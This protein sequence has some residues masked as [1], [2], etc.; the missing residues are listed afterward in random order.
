MSTFWGELHSLDF[1]SF[2][3]RICFE[4]R[5]SNFEFN[6]NGNC[7]QCYID[8]IKA[9]YFFK[10]LEEKIKRQQNHDDKNN[11]QPVLNHPQ[12]QAG[13]KPA[14]FN[15]SFAQSVDAGVDDEIIILLT[16]TGESFI[17]DVFQTHAI[18][19]I[20]IPPFGKKDFKS[21]NLLY[22]TDLIG[23]PT[24]E[25]QP[26]QSDSGCCNGQGR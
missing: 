13:Q 4:F 14:G 19:V 17:N 16:K 23:L 26:G 12:M 7:R 21:R 2:G 24:P 6:Q 5:Y 15:G 18:K 11:Q 20:D 8:K 10:T 25:F 22:K 3:I 1:W 9:F